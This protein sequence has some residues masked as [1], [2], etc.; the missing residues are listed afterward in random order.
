MKI[1]S[2][3]QNE[4]QS[5]NAPS[6]YADPVA[7][8]VSDIVRKILADAELS[9]S[10]L[11]ETGLIVVSDTC[12]LSTI[13]LLSDEAGRGSI[14]PLRFAGASPSIVTGLAALRENMQGPT[15]T[16]TMNPKSSVAAI[17]ALSRLW[18]SFNNIASTIV[19]THFLLR[20]VGHLCKGLFLQSVEHSVDAFLT[21]LCDPTTE[22]I[23]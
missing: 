5:R 14:S 23:S 21:D 17:A 22:T 4:I 12:T 8:A 7:W 11:R 6:L 10:E 18:M 16:L 20:D 13:R 19:V 1:H 3:L 15:L 9:G 2:S